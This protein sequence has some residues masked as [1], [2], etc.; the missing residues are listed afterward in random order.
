MVRREP[1]RQRAG[2]GRSAREA[3]RR[4]REVR[5][6]VFPPILSLAVFPPNSPRRTEGPWPASPPAAAPR[7][8]GRRPR[9]G[10]GRGPDRL[11]RD[12]ATATPPSGI[13]AQLLARGTVAR[14]SHVHVAGIKLATR[15]P[16]DVATVHV[17]FQPGG[18]TGW[19]THPGPA[20]V[21]VTSGQLT[22]HRAKGCGTRTFTAGQT[23]L[24]Y[25]PRD[26]NL[27]RNQTG[28]VTET[29]VTFLLPVGAPVTVDAPAPNCR[30]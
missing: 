7:C 8:R 13:A 19:H 30:L 27:T 2:L 15:G 11:P 23:F 14:A 18:S 29:V 25:G 24:E 22:L 26:V 17:T 1:L 20:L 12:Q 28:G 9:L 3:R 10:A 6:L 4:P 16:V 21:T 5:F